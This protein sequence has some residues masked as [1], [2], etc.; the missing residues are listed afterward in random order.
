MISHIV[1]SWLAWLAKL[2]PVYQD[3]SRPLKII[4]FI[5][6]LCSSC[7]IINEHCSLAGL[8]TRNLSANLCLPNEAYNTNTD[9]KSAKKQEI[10]R[11]KYIL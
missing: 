9:Q 1:Q 8:S 11:R 4:L 5:C 10:L 6:L 7:S 3:R 2:Q